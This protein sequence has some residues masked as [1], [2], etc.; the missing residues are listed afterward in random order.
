MQIE[1]TPLNDCFI[2][3]PTLFEDS[4]G[5]FFES[6]NERTFKKLSGLDIHFVQDNEAKSN[7]NVL[8]GL[9]YQTGDNAQAKLVR[10]L[11]G[12]VLDVV[13]D[14]RKDS[15]TFGKYFSIVLNNI[16][17]IAM[18]VPRGFAHGYVVLEDNTV[19]SYK[20]DNFYN[21]ESEAGVFCFDNTLQIPWGITMQQA[22][23]SDKD[24]ILPA[25]IC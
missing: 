6:F 5:Y 18:F 24:K 11:Q 19:F 2:V 20:C 10:V 1:A 21:K 17:K 12:S 4:R 9:H 13:V 7:T 3:K 16:D 14:M 8:R 23:M 25:F 22:I 15:S